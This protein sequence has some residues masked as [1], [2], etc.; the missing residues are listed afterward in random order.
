MISILPLERTMRRRDSRYQ[1]RAFTLL[2][3]MLV[4]AVL[5]VLVGIAMPMLRGPLKRQ[6][7]DGAAR[8]IRA[9][10]SDARV[11]AM[12]TGRVQAFY[13]QLGG[14]E[15]KVQSWLSAA[16]D[17]EASLGTYREDEA[18]A[19]TTQFGDAKH[20]SLP[21]GIQFVASQTEFSL[22]D[23]A[24]AIVSSINEDTN[25]TGEGDDE[26]AEEEPSSL[27]VRPI[28]FYPDGTSSDA[29]VVLAGQQERM[30]LVRLRGLTGSSRTSVYVDVGRDL[31]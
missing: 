5:I 18:D 25:Q 15:F 14:T 22:R 3:M 21:H 24:T 30:L 13:H 2:E 12:K 19:L 8:Q 29:F 10:W 11:K 1:Q 4:M 31:P 9:A 27:M 7:L 28:L 6:R 16:D 17:L 26:F 20:T 23:E